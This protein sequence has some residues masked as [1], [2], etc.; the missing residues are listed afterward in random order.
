MSESVQLRHGASISIPAGTLNTFS[1]LAPSAKF[2]TIS[3]TGRMS[4]FF[5][6]LAE[7]DPTDDVALGTVSVRHEVE[8]A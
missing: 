3:Q 8:L 4:A 7:A 6:D 2:L 1:V 5:A